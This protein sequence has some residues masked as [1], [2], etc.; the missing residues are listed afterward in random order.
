MKEQRVYRILIIISNIIINIGLWRTRAGCVSWSRLVELVLRDVRG[1]G[2]VVY[3]HLRRPR[4]RP[5]VI[6]VTRPGRRRWLRQ[7]RSPW[8]PCGAAVGTCTPGGR[9]CVVG[10]VS[11]LPG[12]TVSYLRRSTAWR[13][14]I[15]IYHW[16]IVT[17]DNNNL[18]S[19]IIT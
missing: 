9:P 18:T 12:R 1:S 19:T 13:Q 11:Q 14:F 6:P 8:A 4:L 3:G 7:P 5:A 15:F 2:T 17:T 16:V 10:E